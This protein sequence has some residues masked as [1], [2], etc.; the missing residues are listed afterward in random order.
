VYVIVNIKS[1]VCNRYVASEFR[2]LFHGGIDIESLCEAT[3]VFNRLKSSGILNKEIN[4]ILN[5]NRLLDISGY[6]N[7]LKCL[8]S[9]PHRKFLFGCI[10]I[11]KHF[12]FV[13]VPQNDRYF[14]ANHSFFGFVLRSH[15]GRILKNSNTNERSTRRIS[16]LNESEI[17]K[18]RAADYPAEPK[19]AY[20][21]GIRPI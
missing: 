2:G 19:L 10:C 9:F 3:K 7:K 21:M 6:V 15:S 5:L 12:I 16:F 13:T 17:L 4:K 11:R 14:Y 8:L 20:K 18:K 1:G